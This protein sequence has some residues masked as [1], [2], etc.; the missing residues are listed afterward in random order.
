MATTF[1]KIP[2][3]QECILES[4]CIVIGKI[5]KSI[6]IEELSI[7]SPRRFYGYFKLLIEKILFGDLLEK[8]LLI[9]LLGEK[10]GEKI[11]YVAEFSENQLYLFLLRKDIDAY[12]PSFLNIHKVTKNNTVLLSK[13]LDKIREGFTEKK[14]SKISEEEISLEEV[15]SMI[16]SV[17][18][19]HEKQP[20]ME[21]YSS[22]V[23]ELKNQEELLGISNYGQNSS[24][25]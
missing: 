22:E 15:V 19:F 8:N 9:K 25:G 5:S 3:F 17:K 6:K 4:D 11:N 13:N 2:T 18:P 24:I 23:F 12:S 10:T 7:P 21:K 1:D 16:E 14:K 20:S